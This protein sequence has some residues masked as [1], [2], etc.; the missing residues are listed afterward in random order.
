M[1]SRKICLL[2][3][4][5]SIASVLS[6]RE[7]TVLVY[8]VENL[9]D[10]DGIAEFSDY[11]QT[12]DASGEPYTPGHL[13]T[14][15]RHI[16]EVLHAINEG[17]GP[18]IVLFQEI[19][20]DQTPFSNGGDS[21]ESFLTTFVSTTV[22][23]M[24]TTGFSPT[25]AGLPA[26]RLLLKYLVDSGMEPYALAK[27]EVRPNE[28]IYAHN[29]VVFSR[30]PIRWVR[31]RA[32]ASA[33]DLLVVGLEVDGHELVLMNNHWRAGA[34][35]PR[36]EPIRVQNAHV[37]QAEVS[38]VLLKNPAADLI[39]AGDLNS[40]YNHA[41]VFPE[42][43]ETGIN[44]VLGS[45][46]NER[47]FVAGQRAGL[48]NL[49]GEVPPEERGSEIWRGEWGTLMHLLLS[50]GLYDEA[51]VQYIDNSFSRM[52]LP[53]RNVD[54]R[55]GTPLRWVQ[56]GNGSGFSDHLPLVARFR[57]V[58]TANPQRFQQLTEPVWGPAPAAALIP[59]DYRL[60]DRD[61]IPSALTLD[62]LS[63]KEVIRYLGEVFQM[64]G[65][66]GGSG[67]EVRIGDVV[68]GLY[69]V[70]EA[71]RAVIEA[72]P[73]GSRLRAY[74][75]LGDFYG[76]IQFVIHRTDWMLPPDN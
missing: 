15:I 46:I 21:P 23:E 62:G 74:G 73:E 7:F 67:S 39:V 35:N 75:Q 16:A 56:R 1:L 22:E 9:F 58:D 17:R 68:Y 5:I 27:P 64:E 34:S 13:L 44:H 40:H 37:V 71:L 20:L 38:A 32:V 11:R 47:A 24:L 18:E 2:L 41:A 72:R 48:Y 31:Q 49:W 65:V 4:A 26:E 6:A 19:E 57:T 61:D 8:N 52:R 33:R 55:F 25:V 29:N 66:L 12:S 70:P 76:T 28:R 51:G 14:K 36:A 10:V 59:V 42:L 69:V 63:P 3:G 43:E 60:L 53:G 30:F 45:T 54:T 50:R